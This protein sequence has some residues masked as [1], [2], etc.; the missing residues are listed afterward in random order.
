MLKHTTAVTTLT[1]DNSSR[2][3]HCPCKIPW[4]FTRDQE[5][6][7]ILL[8]KRCVQQRYPPPAN[9]S[10][11]VMGDFRTVPSPSW[12]IAGCVQLDHMKIPTTPRPDVKGL[13]HWNSLLLS[14]SKASSKD[15]N[16]LWKSFHFSNFETAQLAVEFQNSFIIWPH[17]T[18]GPTGAWR[19]KRG[20]KTVRE[21]L[22]E[23]SQ[24]LES[25]SISASQPNQITDSI[26]QAARYPK[27]TRFMAAQPTIP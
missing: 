20:T 23:G 21:I 1:E 15:N 12:L 22:K 7:E 3:L 9:Q 24:V 10:E 6:T 26:L 5:R 25:P 16:I 4:H 8:L 13:Q 27:E 14:T 19:G 17:F 11:C 2:Q 18:K